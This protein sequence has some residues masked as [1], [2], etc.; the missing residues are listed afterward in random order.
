M[1]LKFR[2]YDLQSKT[3]RY[4]DLDTYNRDEHDC[5]GNITQ[6]TGLYDKNGK[7]I[8]EG[9]I[10]EHY[11]DGYKQDN[12]YTVENMWDLRIAMADS[13]SYFRIQKD[14]CI[15]GNVYENLEL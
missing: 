8:Y 12:N 13:D 10:L 3:I 2:D 15:V 14:V 9:D 11:I 7:E 1:K 5:Y 4:F 6:F